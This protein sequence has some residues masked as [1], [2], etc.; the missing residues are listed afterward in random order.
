M[1]A[2]SQLP[3]QGTITPPLLAELWGLARSR[4]EVQSRQA[5]SAHSPGQRPS[6][7]GEMVGGLGPGVLYGV[8]ARRPSLHIPHLPTTPPLQQPAAYC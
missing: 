1:R 8:K 6:G 4:K 7:L 5:S 2:G 3:Y